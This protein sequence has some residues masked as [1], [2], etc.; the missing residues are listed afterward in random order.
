MNMLQKAKSFYFNANA[1][2]KNKILEAIDRNEHICT[3]VINAYE[4]LKGLKWK[5]SKH[6]GI[7]PV[8]LVPN[9]RS[10][11]YLQPE[12]KDAENLDG[13]CNHQCR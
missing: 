5:N 2:V 9:S 6:L 1:T 7:T 8:T 13:K 10:R 3:T 12:A 4:I 11:V